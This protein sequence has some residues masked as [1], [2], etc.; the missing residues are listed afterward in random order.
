MRIKLLLPA[1]IIRTTRRAFNRASAEIP[2]R[3][4]KALL[5]DWDAAR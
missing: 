5:R 2:D 1:T 3:S 4:A